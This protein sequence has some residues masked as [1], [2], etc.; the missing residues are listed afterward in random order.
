MGSR[1]DDGS[2]QTDP[3]LV[4]SVDVGSVDRE[5]Q[6]YYAILHKGLE[7]L[8]ILVFVWGPGTNPLQTLRDNCPKTMELYTLKGWFLMFI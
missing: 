4:E 3:R 7:H 5:F 2:L 8:R 6:L 1:Y